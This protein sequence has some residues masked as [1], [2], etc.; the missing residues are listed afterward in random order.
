MEEGLLHATPHRRGRAGTQVGATG[1]L[2]TTYTAGVVRCSHSVDS[3]LLLRTLL[4]EQQRLQTA[5]CTDSMSDTVSGTCSNK[6]LSKS[7]ACCASVAFVLCIYFSAQSTTV[8]AAMMN[9]HIA[10]LVNW[11]NWATAFITHGNLVLLCRRWLD[12]AGPVPYKDGSRLGPILPREHVLEHFESHVLR[13]PD[14]LK[15]LRDLRRKQAAVLVG[16]GWAAAGQ[17][18]IIVVVPS[19]RLCALSAGLLIYCT[20]SFSRVLLAL[21]ALSTLQA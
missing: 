9:P 19:L 8:R 20:A 12:A 5:A 18:V 16:G 10:D 11:V 15:G 14:C 7:L 21:M 4:L 17:H 2:A 13:C 3:V 6:P 1:S